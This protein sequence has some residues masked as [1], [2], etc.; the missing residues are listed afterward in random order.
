MPR[1]RLIFP[2]RPGESIERS[3]TVHI[4]S[5]TEIYAVGKVV[6]HH[7]RRWRVTQAPLDQPEDWAEADV[8]LWPVEE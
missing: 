1:Y 8:M 7:G 4:D 3:P 6:E 5:G 2:P